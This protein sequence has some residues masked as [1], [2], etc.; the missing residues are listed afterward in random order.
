MLTM[1]DRFDVVSGDVSIKAGRII[2]V[3][4]EP[5]V[6][7]STAGGLE[8]GSI[9]LDVCRDVIDHSVL[10][11]ED[12]ILATMRMVRESQGWLMEGAAGTA[13]AAFLQTADRY[14][15]KT[16]VVVICG[17]NVSE[18]VLTQISRR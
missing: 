8:S 13:L 16:V 15:G 7:E 10:V 9:T 11:S 1:N 12:E 17:G 18:Q 2:D 5:T 6:S 3:A 14:A 4:E